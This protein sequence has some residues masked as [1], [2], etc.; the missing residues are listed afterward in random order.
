[1]RRRWAVGFGAISLSASV[2]LWSSGARAEHTVEL[3]WS[4]PQ[5]CPDKAAVVAEVDTLISQATT[6]G[7]RRVAAAGVVEREGDDYVLTLEV[8]S[9]GDVGRRVVRGRS[10]ERLGEAAALIVA[11]AYDPSLGAVAEEPDPPAASP[12]TAE[13]TT[14]PPAE[15]SPRTDQPPPEPTTP[16]PTDDHDEGVVSGLV[17]LGGVATVG[18]LPAPSAGLSLRLGLAYERLDV[19]LEGAFWLGRNVNVGSGPAGG[20]LSFQSASLVG[21]G[22]VVRLLGDDLDL[23]LCG[24]FSVGRMRGDGF[25]VDRPGSAESAWVA[26][27]PG[28]MASWSVVPW[29]RLRLEVSAMFAALRPTWE[30]QNVGALDDPGVASAR[31]GLGLDT[32]F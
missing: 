18:A 14:P 29:L 2:S 25:G 28:T 7:T 20:A 15:V 17:G 23:G 21:C 32:K 9:D 27:G 24:R 19:A 31:L 26:M 12:A 11:I 8:D 4:A 1:M 30:L 13:P 6:S 3:S 5:G 22:A 10:C 16:P